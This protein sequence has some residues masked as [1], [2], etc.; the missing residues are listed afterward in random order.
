M[1]PNLQYSL[2]IDGLPTPESFFKRGI[3]EWDYFNNGQYC[4]YPAAEPFQWKSNVKESIENEC[5]FMKSQ[6]AVSAR[7]SAYVPWLQTHMQI[8]WIRNS[9]CSSKDQ[10]AT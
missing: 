4:Q 2:I 7:S 1:V 10:L 6:S 3:M 9:H 5:L 8:P